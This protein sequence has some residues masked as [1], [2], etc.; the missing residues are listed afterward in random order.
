M[1]PPDADTVSQALVSG[2]R[3]C[4]PQHF[5]SV[6]AGSDARN[7][8][9]SA[10][11]HRQCFAYSFSNSGNKTLSASQSPRSAGAVDPAE[12]RASQLR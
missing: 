6:S 10:I 11:G 4:S 1:V 7:S 2:S 5:W 9:C 8:F 12:M 3:F